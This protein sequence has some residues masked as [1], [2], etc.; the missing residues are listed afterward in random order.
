MAD[1]SFLQSS[2]LGG[3]WS[4]TAQGRIEYQRYKTGMNV[5]FNGIPLEEGAWTRRPGSRFIAPVRGA[6]GSL[7]RVLTFSLQ[8][9]Q[10]VT[11]VLTDAVARFIYRTGSVYTNDIQGI[12]AISGATPARRKRRHPPP[13]WVVSYSTG[14][15]PSY[16]P[17]TYSLS[18]SSRR[19]S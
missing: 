2:F 1:A 6:A 11:M 16:V 7:G 3:E 18:R 5:C 13:P 12:T 17:D 10:P 8:A 14:V 15:T 19:C 9:D 4:L